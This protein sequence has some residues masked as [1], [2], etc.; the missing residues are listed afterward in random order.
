MPP[1]ALDEQ[2]PIALAEVLARAGV[3]VA[4]V[5]RWPDEDLRT[6]GDDIILATTTA[7]G[8]VLITRDANTLPKLAIECTVAERHHA[9]LIVLPKSIGQQDIGGALRAILHTIQDATSESLANIVTFA[10]HVR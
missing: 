3:D 7:T 6:L 2:L 1:V 5:S 9:G 8:R 4:H 10:Q